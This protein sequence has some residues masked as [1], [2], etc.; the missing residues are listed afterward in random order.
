VEG[1]ELLSV[2]FLNGGLIPGLHRPTLQQQLL[3]NKYLGPWLGPLLTESRFQA[4]LVKIF[5]PATQPPQ[6]FLE[7]SYAALTFNGGHMIMHECVL[8]PLPLPV[9]SPVMCFL[10]YRKWG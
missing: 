7:D 3:H 10:R 2:A 9:P 6:A 4:A 1:L 8:F 5:G